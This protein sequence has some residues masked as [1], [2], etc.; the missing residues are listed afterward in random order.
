MH[1]I[2]KQLRSLIPIEVLRSSGSFFT[3]DRLAEKAIANLPNK[4][5][6]DSSCLDPTCGVGNLLIAASKCLPIFESL[7]KT[8]GLWGHCLR[9]FDLHSEFVECTKLRLINE[10]ISRGAKPVQKSLEELES[11][12][13]YV[14]VGDIFDHLNSLKIATHLL[15]NPPYKL[16]KLSKARTWGAGKVN[17]AA[18]FVD[19]IVQNA[20][21]GAAVTAVLPEVLRSGSRYAAWRGMISSLMDSSVEVSGRFD[22]RTDVDVINLYGSV[23]G[24]IGEGSEVW[25]NYSKGPCVG[26]YFDICVGPLVAYRDKD[27]GVEAPFIYPRMLQ[28]WVEVEIDAPLRRTSTRLIKPPI[29]VVNRTSSPR[30]LYRAA[31]TIIKGGQPVAIENHLIVLTPKK[32]G[33]ESC[34]KLLD[35]LRHPNTNRH[36]NETIRCRHLT[37]GAVK[38]IPW[39]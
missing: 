9:G 15:V 1:T 23:R 31:A 32:G 6:P 27:K 8:I 28:K 13:I 36:L 38:E 3:G 16:E 10:A 34:R 5:A 26:E 30:D 29:V 20:S 25:V 24:E 4:I 21:V 33:I 22:S 2:E 18:V 17:L 7:D 39:K 14:L 11:L 35:V 12:F 37:V 19:E